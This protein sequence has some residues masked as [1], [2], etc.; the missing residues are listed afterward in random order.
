LKY[1]VTVDKGY[2]P[3]CTTELFTI[4]KVLNTK[5]ITYKIKDIN[6][7]EIEL[8]KFDKQDQK[9]EVEEMVRKNIF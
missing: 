2:L 1:K 8:V 3:N 5:P 6:D 7:E 9:Y 4:S